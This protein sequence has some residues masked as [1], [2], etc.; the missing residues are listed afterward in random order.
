MCFL[1]VGFVFITFYVFVVFAE[2]VRGCFDSGE[3]V[4]ALLRFCRIC[5]SIASILPDMCQHC[6]DFAEYVSALLRF[7]QICEG[8]AI[9]IFDLS[10]R[11]AG[12]RLLRG[13]LGGRSPLSE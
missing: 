5:V 3:Y 2:Y 13:G 4:S 10:T 9:Q 6:F 12:G 8:F 1:C 7:L 11:E